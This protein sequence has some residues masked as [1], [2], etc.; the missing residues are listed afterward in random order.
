MEDKLISFET[1]K[2]AK[3]KEF[4]YI[5]DYQIYYNSIGYL[6]RLQ[7][8]EED[9][10]APTQS[11][12]QKWLREIHNIHIDIRTN[13][14]SGGCY[15]FYLSQTRAP[16]YTLFISVKDSDTYEEALEYALKESLKLI[17]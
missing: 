16:F 5:L 2:L 9:I 7:H 8:S 17:K 15:F 12:L 3:E 4:K 14:I 13:T 11:L 10:P 1:A 6:N